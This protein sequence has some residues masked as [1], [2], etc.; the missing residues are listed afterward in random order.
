MHGAF[1]MYGN[2][3]SKS[4][5][6]QKSATSARAMLPASPS[7]TLTTPVGGPS[8]SPPGRTTQNSRSFPGP[9]GPKNSCSWL[10]LS[11]KMDR[12][13]VDMRILN[14]NGAWSALSP[15]PMDVT[16][17]TRFTSFCFIA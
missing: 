7:M 3:S 6:R 12:I 16:T 1:P 2:A 14:T 17:A 5:P 8:P 15:A 9:A 4:A 10:F 11:V 13:T